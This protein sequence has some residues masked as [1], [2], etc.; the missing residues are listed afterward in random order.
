MSCSR[1]TSM[2]ALPSDAMVTSPRVTRRTC[3][4]ILSGLKLVTFFSS[5]SVIL[6]KMYFPSYFEHS[7][8]FYDIQFF[9]PVPDKALLDDDF[10]I[11]G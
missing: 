11:F 2:H 10:Q 9:W 8:K 1:K 6:N 4:E 7:I 3:T 5:C